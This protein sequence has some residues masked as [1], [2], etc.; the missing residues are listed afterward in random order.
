MQVPVLFWVLGAT[1]LDGLLA[2]AGIFT[3][4]MKEKEVRQIIK[5]LI[6]FSAG[7]LLAGAFFHL[8]AESLEEMQSQEAFFLLFTGFILFFLIE[9]FL[10]WHHCHEGHCEV[11]PMSYLIIIGDSVHNFIDGLIIAASFVAG[12]PFGILTTVLIIG[13]ELPQELGNFGIMV[14]GG[15]EKKKALLYNFIAQ[16]TAVIGGLAGYF[17]SLNAGSV[18]F[19]LPFAAGGFIY[20][21]A[22]DLIP[23]LHKEKNLSKSLFSFALFLFGILFMAGLKILLE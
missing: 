2:F 7:A 1:V 16:A 13:H 19:L 21:S 8:L 11:H 20:I 18:S 14:H 9:R 23:E 5:G 22:S 6:A 17:F 3:L 15:I 10:H 12:I 4:K